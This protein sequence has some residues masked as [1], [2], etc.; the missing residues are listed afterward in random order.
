MHEL[1]SILRVTDQPHIEDQLT[2]IPNCL[3]IS[4]DLGLSTSV[5]DGFSLAFGV[6]EHRASIQNL[7][8]IFILQLAALPALNDLLPVVGTFHLL[9]KSRAVN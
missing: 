6:A 4:D 2:P 1:G 7:V 3:V 8:S 9:T 5:V